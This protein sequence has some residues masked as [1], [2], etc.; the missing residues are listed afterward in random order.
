MIPTQ[1][2]NNFFTIGEKLGNGAFG[3]VY[4]A[5]M[6]GGKDVAIKFENKDK[7]SRYLQNEI[8]IYRKLKGLVGFPKSI[9]N[10]STANHYFIAVD[11]LGPSLL[12]LFKSHG[13]SFGLSTVLK[14]GVQILNRLE[15]LH[16]KNIVHCDLKPENV[17]VG[18]N[19]SSNL[20]LIDYGFST[21]IENADELREPVRINFVRGTLK[22]MSVGA[23]QGIVAFQNDIE[24][25]G[26]L[27]GF[28]ISGKMPWDAENIVKKV[29]NFDQKTIY[30]K[31][32][33]LKNS[34]NEYSQSWPIPLQVFLTASRNIGYLE[35]P[36]YNSLREVLK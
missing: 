16:A 10:G 15:I 24:S 13:K 1:I 18:Y 30:G 26:Y 5:K 11:L 25:L 27:L 22:F 31:T 32:L 36:D 35:R 23:H 19:D 33:E 17:V 3:D 9:A 20:Y 21:E 14:I 8:E 34:I 4:K 29:T 12:T 2:K 6:Q 7:K 28:L